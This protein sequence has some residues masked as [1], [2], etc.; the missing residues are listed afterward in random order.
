MTDNYEFSKSCQTQGLEEESP[1]AKKDWAYIGDINSGVYSNSGLSLVTF[2]LSSIFNSSSLV[3]M[4]ES[5]ITVPITIVSAYTSDNSNG[6]VVAPVSFTA[7]WAAHGL[8]AGYHNLLHAADLQINGKTMNQ[9]TP[10]LNVYTGVKL[11][12]QMSQDDLKSQGSSMGFQEVLDNAQSMKWNNTG[13]MTSSAAAAYPGSNANSLALTAGFVGGNGLPNNNAFATSGGLIQ[14]LQAVTTAA[15]LAAAATTFSIAANVGIVTGMFVQ[16]PG[17]Y[18]LAPNTVVTGVNA[19][20][21]TIT[22]SP[23][24]VNANAV[25]TFLTFSVY[26]SNSGDATTQGVQNVGAYNNGY[27]SRLKKYTDVTNGTAQYLYG[28]NPGGTGA[29]ATTIMTTTLL[30]NEFKPYSI[31]SGSY[32]ITYDLAVIRCKDILDSIKS[33]PLSKRVD[34]QLRL[35]FNTGVVGSYIQRGGV[36]VTSASTNTFTN[37]C[38]LLQTSLQ[39]IPSTA[40]GIVSGLFI[41]R[42]TATSI[43][44]GVNLATSAAAHPLQQCRFYYPNV[45]LKPE[46]LRLYQSENLN[47]KIVYTD[48]LFNQVNAITSGGTFSGILQ[49]GVS[50]IRGIWII[51]FIAS[52]IYGSVPAAAVTSGVTTLAQYQSPFDT[53]PMTN[54]PLSIINLQVTVGG[55]N[56][57]MNTLNQTFENFLQQVSLYEKLNSSDLGLSCGLFNQYYWEN[58]LRVYYVDCTRGMPGDL[59]TPRTVLAS[60]GNNTNVTC[61]YLTFVEYFT[62]ATINVET[63]VVTK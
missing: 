63:G 10:Y 6:T 61:D 12:S 62:E 1:Y 24:V 50:N 14:V 31:V 33:Y 42:A 20:G 56:V 44:G 39:D 35:Y 36:M 46:K 3:S 37:T 52:S 57:L 58:A 11:L 49:T 15:G 34:A 60:W 2:D 19:A 30:Q 7:P 32:I 43:F 5:Y 18:F 23:A 48:I 28:S 47:K 54:G 9:Y 51:P 41:S 8:K 38:P 53:A 26:A 40:S 17:G 27:S 13:N 4:S 21:T 22:F 25:I 55:Q 16:A 29:T 45:L 59:M